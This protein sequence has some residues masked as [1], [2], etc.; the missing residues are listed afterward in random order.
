MAVRF[1]LFAAPGAAATD[2]SLQETAVHPSRTPENWPKSGQY[3]PMGLKNGMAR[4]MAAKA[5]APETIG[6]RAPLHGSASLTRRCLSGNRC[7]C[8]LTKLIA[9][10][11][12]SRRIKRIS[13]THSGQSLSYHTVTSEDWRRWISAPSDIKRPVSLAAFRAVFHGFPS[14]SSICGATEKAGHRLRR[15]CAA[16]LLLACKRPGYQWPVPGCLLNG[17]TTS[18]VIQPP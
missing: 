2:G 8:M 3:V 10:R 13:R 5:A 14:P 6:C 11:R 18:D 12:S 1:S 9:C 7:S 4:H 15:P 17:P 16:D